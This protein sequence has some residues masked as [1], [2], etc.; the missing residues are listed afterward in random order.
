MKCPYP[1]CRK[2]YNDESWPKVMDSW[3]TPS[4]TGGSIAE[5]T[6][7]NRLYIVT[8]RCRFCQQ[9]FHEI[10]VGRENFEDHTK[11]FEELDP[12]L[13]LLVTYPVS[14]TKFEAKNIPK[15]IIDAFNEA[16]RCRSVG[17][18]TGTGGCLR[19]AVYTLC[20]DRNTGG[21]D[22]R[23]KIENLP[24]KETYKELLKQIKW[25]GDN[26]TKPGEEKYTMEMIDVALEILPI[27]IDDMY[28][29][30]EKTTEAARLLAKARS[31]N[32][33]IEVKKKK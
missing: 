3:I 23:E 15:T 20:D 27:L 32:Q 6:F 16:E 8:R 19:K 1:S 12:T 33:N 2:D 4:G 25:I 31:I 10:Y 21:R 18:L 9:L 29:K 11:D 13:E 24:V 7:H 22:Y 26:T 28:I 17:S 30:D 5:R 14:K